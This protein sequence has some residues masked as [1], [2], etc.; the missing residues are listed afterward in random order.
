[1]CPP[2]EEQVVRRLRIENAMKNSL[3]IFFWDESELIDLELGAAEPC[4]PNKPAHRHQG[5]AEPGLVAHWP[6]PSGGSLGRYFSYFPEI[7]S[8]NFQDVLRTFISAQKQHQGN[9]AENSVS[10]R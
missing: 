8:G 2:D 1:M 9:C 4:G 5:V 10:P 6:I 3:F 7:F